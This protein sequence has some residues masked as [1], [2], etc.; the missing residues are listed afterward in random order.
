ML[1]IDGFRGIELKD[2][3]VFDSYFTKFPPQISEYTFTN[4]YMWR[5]VYKFQWNIMQEHLVLIALRDPEKIMLFPPIGTQPDRA[6][7]GL[8]ELADNLKTSIELIRCPENILDLIR[9]N[10]S[11]NAQIHI[12]ED[13]DNWDYVY[14]Q[15]DL[16]N[17]PGKNYE[18]ERKKLNKFKNRNKWEYRPLNGDLIHK[19][20]NLQEQWCEW[21]GCDDESSLANEN[22]GIQ[23][24]LNN[25]ETLRFGG[26]IVLVEDQ[27]VAFT[28]A[29]P[30]DTSTMVC[31]VEKANQEYVGA[32]Q[33]INQLFAASLPTSFEFINREQDVGE[34]NL[35]RAKENY[36]P[37]L[38]VKKFKVRLI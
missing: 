20:I 18:N 11:L 34:I 19:C 25:W 9:S 12:N 33:A 35:R 4:L 5:N 22:A 3:P 38:F 29:E 31:H 24:V 28:L 7:L 23:D 14:Q 6:I 30:L 37:I 32:Y 36:H 2:K 21:R 17:L 1:Q 27:I 8:M 16:A 10:S 13:R 26:G 15:S